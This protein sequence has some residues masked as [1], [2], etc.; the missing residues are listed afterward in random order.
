MLNQVRKNHMTKDWI[1]YK[2]YEKRRQLGLELGI[3]EVS[4]QVLIN[5]GIDVVDGAKHFLNPSLN[6]LHNPFLFSQMEKSVTRIFAA[7]DGNEKILIYGDYDVDG[8]TSVSILISVLRSLGARA[9]F[10][11]PNR[12]EEGYG[13]NAPA[14]KQ[15]KDDNTNL[16][17]TADCGISAHSE[18]ELANKYGMDV[19]VTDHHELPKDLPEAFSIINPKMPGCNYPFSG[20]AGAGVAFKLA[21]A[22]MIKINGVEGEREII[23]KYMELVSL[24]TIADIVPLTG[25]NRVI[26]KFGLEKLKNTTFPG[27][28]A[29]LKVSGLEN[30]KVDS[31]GVGFGLAPRINAVGR[32]GDPSL[33]IQLLITDSQEEAER[34]AQI[35]DEQN[36]ERKIQEGRIFQEALELIE[37]TVDQGKDKV[38]VVAHENWHTG[39]IGIVASRISEMFYKPCIL[40]SLEDNEAIGSARSIENFHLYDA[41]SHS[42][43][44]LLR[45]GGHEQ[46]AGL[47]LS[48]DKID[49]FRH[50]INQYAHKVIEPQDLLPKLKIDC[51][52]SLDDVSLDLVHEL[53]RLEPFGAENPSPILSA[54]SINVSGYRPVGKDGR[55]LKLTI[56]TEQG[57]VIDAIGFGL[58]GF[59]DLLFDNPHNLDIAFSVEENTWNGKTDLQLNIVDIRDSDSDNPFISYLFSNEKN[60]SYHMNEAQTTDY[61]LSIKMEKDESKKPYKLKL[62]KSLVETVKGQ[63]YMGNKKNI[64]SGKNTKDKENGKNQIYIECGKNVMGFKNND[65]KIMEDVEDAENHMSIVDDILDVIG[66]DKSALNLDKL[67]FYDLL[68]AILN[69]CNVLHSTPFLWIPAIAGIIPPLVASG[70]LQG[71][72]IFICS[73]DLSAKKLYDNISYIL[74]NIGITIDMFSPLQTVAKQSKIKVY[75][76][77][78]ALDILITTEKYFNMYLKDLSMYKKIPEILCYFVEKPKDKSIEL[79][80]NIMESIESSL[81]IFK[82]PSIYLITDLNKEKFEDGVFHYCAGNSVSINDFAIN[83]LEINKTDDKIKLVEEFIAKDEKVLIYVNYPQR[84]VN[85]ARILS[86]QMRDKN[87]PFYH[88]KMQDKDRIVLAHLVREKRIDVLVSTGSF[89]VEGLGF[90]FDHILFF[91]LPY[92]KGQFLSQCMAAGENCGIQLLFSELDVANTLEVMTEYYPN[93]KKLV[94]IYLG[95]K[96]ACNGN[97]YFSG[98]K[99][100]LVKYS[101]AFCSFQVNEGFLCIALQIFQEMELITVTYKEL[102]I[103]VRFNVGNGNKV[104]L[105]KSITYAEG[106]LIRENYRKWAED[107][108]SISRMDILEL[109]P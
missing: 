95:I 30:K 96:K 43:D 15:A 104:D 85:I 52:V 60:S 58:A 103:N 25:E 98:T 67:E 68:R 24:A 93:R 69:R 40:L 12:L 1:V 14:I 55:H 26:A 21:Q 77:E 56:K 37:A 100:Q 102:N 36:K 39:I 86:R 32:M 64:Q 28:K 5:R 38:I 65:M 57:K 41:L 53:D 50:K 71:P 42:S 99:K 22:L 20:L 19:I 59:C 44:L 54:K 94:D 108:L 48:P 84:A 49:A 9:Q 62:L 63:G 90:S 33:G 46:A 61:G 31:I 87:I 66:I 105:T 101:D 4:A 82:S 10:Y 107:M 3:S 79:S 45:F 17:I 7:I 18:I 76:K 97:D 78:N 106:K 81:T 74:G 92:A 16:I 89:V 70:F 91:D 6:M 35:L 27:L 13:L 73:T 88:G 8:I 51:E 83:D 11:V 23:N 29:L 80:K 2:P 75:L 109:I 72:V 47:L 34:I